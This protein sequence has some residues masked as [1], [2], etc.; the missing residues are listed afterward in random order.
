MSD[1]DD[2]SWEANRLLIHKELENLQLQNRAFGDKLE[3][4]STQVTTMSTHVAQLN[5][6]LWWGLSI[7]GSLLVAAI[8]GGVQIFVKLAPMASR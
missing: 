7:V 3:M 8:W 4:L 2:R 5:R 6:I 1:N